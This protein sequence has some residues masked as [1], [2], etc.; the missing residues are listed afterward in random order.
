M[1]EVATELMHPCNV[2]PVTEIFWCVVVLRVKIHLHPNL[3]P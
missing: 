3:K 1:E 2:R